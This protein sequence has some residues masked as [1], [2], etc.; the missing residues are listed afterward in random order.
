MAPKITLAMLMCGIGAATAAGVAAA[1]TP[2]P[3]VLAIA[4]KYDPT[5]LETDSGARRLYARIVNAADAVCP[6]Y[7]NPHGLNPQVQACRQRAIENA[8]SKVHDPRLV[9]VHL[10]STKRG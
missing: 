3:D 6:E 2:D 4:V 8:V 7:Y 9:A 10:S 5:T 1:A